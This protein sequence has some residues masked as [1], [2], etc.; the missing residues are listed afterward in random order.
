MGIQKKSITLVLGG[1]RSGKSRYA[2][3]LA[4]GWDR[5][6]FIATAQRSDDEMR[7]RIERH[8]QE[9]PASWSTVEVQV[10]LDLAVDRHG[11]E[12]EVLLI[13]CLALYAANMMA[14]EHNN[15]EKILERVDRLCQALRKA[16]SSVVL[17][18]NEVGSGVHPSHPSGRFFRDLLGRINQQIAQVADNVLLMVAGIP[19]AVKGQVTLRQS[20]T[21]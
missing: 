18:S 8:R 19:L 3:Q 13:D 16:G 11:L 20:V 15:E 14:I 7:E 5:V 4:S 2:Q 21:K 1:A 9:R 12:S 6:T 10:D 17:V